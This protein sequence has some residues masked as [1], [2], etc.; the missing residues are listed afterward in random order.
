MNTIEIISNYTSPVP[1]AVSHPELIFY[2]LIRHQH[3]PV[4]II[5][6]L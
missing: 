6:D 2:F 4:T 5:S 1:G 3:N